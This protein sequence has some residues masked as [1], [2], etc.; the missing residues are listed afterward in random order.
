MAQRKGINSFGDRRR[1]NGWN[2][3]FSENSETAHEKSGFPST[4]YFQK[5]L[6]NTSQECCRDSSSFLGKGAELDVSRSVIFHLLWTGYLFKH[7]QNFKKCHP[8]IP[9]LDNNSFAH[10]LL[11]EM[12]AYKMCFP[13]CSSVRALFPPPFIY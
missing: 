11:P 7:L 4:G 9:S 1:N 8:A 10:W 12:W 6:T 5:R 2:L 3:S 13:S